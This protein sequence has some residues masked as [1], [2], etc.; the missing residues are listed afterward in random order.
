MSHVTRFLRV[1]TV[2]VM[3]VGSASSSDNLL[4]IGP[5]IPISY[6]IDNPKFGASLTFMHEIGVSRVLRVCP[7]VSYAFI[8]FDDFTS[9]DEDHR[10]YVDVRIT[11]YW[12]GL[13]LHYYPRPDA[14]GLKSF[15]LAGVGI[16]DMNIDSK[17]YGGIVFGS[18]GRI[19][20][21][22]S[23]I[24]SLGG[25]IIIKHRWFVTA[26]LEHSTGEAH[27]TDLPIQVGTNF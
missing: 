17:G 10:R 2:I 16:N 15:L 1:I 27:F 25:G 26:R 7:S 6:P 12:L 22:R 23:L 8:A 4:V 13:D 21:E 11:N 9:T 3:M 5:V 20:D 14:T 19:L 18:S 24:L